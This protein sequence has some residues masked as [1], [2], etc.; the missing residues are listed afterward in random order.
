MKTVK[1]SQKCVFFSYSD[2]QS[3][4]CANASLLG[5]QKAVNKRILNKFVKAYFKPQNSDCIKKTEQSLGRL[6]TVR[7][8]GSK[9]QYPHF[10]WLTD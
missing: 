3:W 9:I 6:E 2:R 5:S 4:G 1:T 7:K 10:L 8:S